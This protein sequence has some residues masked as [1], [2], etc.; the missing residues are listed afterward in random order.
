[1]IRC[2]RVYAAVAGDDGYRVLVDRLWPRGCK[3]E[4]L[5]LDAWL[6]ELAPSA[7]LRKAFH[8]AAER[9]E[10]FR[11]LYRG[12]L[13][14]H[15]EHWWALL[16]KARSGTLTLLFAAREEQLNN[17]RVLEEFLEEELDRQQ[18]ASSPVCYA[19]ERKS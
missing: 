10:E 13:A 12:E 3:K 5:R 7:E 1:M 8:H 15:P 6:R 17:A 9:F 18:P 2:K 16:D 19:G 11:L 14:A 4:S